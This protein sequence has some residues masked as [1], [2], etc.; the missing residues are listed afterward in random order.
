M[1]VKY[2]LCVADSLPQAVQ[3]GG[4]A[5]GVQALPASP[6]EGG[7]GQP[8]PPPPAR[9]AGGSTVRTVQYSTVQYSTVQYCEDSGVGVSVGAG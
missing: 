2:K 5:R 7:P 3:R 1:K 4:A 8:R 6:A 9:R